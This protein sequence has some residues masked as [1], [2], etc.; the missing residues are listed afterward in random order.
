MVMNVISITHT[1][2]KIPWIHK[3]VTKAERCG[4]SHKYTSIHSFY[5]VKY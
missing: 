5:S 4:K 2:T 1:Y 3:C